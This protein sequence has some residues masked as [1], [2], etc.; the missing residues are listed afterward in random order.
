MT[1]NRLSR[2]S[3]LQLGI[4]LGAYAA[5]TRLSWAQSV[6]LRV[7]WFGTQTRANRTYPALDL[8]E[9]LHPGVTLNPETTA[10]ADYWPLLATQ[11]AG[12]NAPD[13][14]TM[15]PAYTGEYAR[16]DA[17]LPLDEF[18]G[19]GLDLSA[20]PEA[21]LDLGRID[22]KLYG[23]PAGQATQALFYSVTD[24]EAAGLPPPNETTTWEQ[25]AELG[26]E[27]HK[28]LPEVYG[29]AEACSEEQAFS[30]WLN[31]RGKSLY[32]ADGGLNYDGADAG[33]WFA[34]WEAMRQSGACVPADIAAM[35]KDNTETNALTTGYAAV[36][37]SQANLF[38]GYQAVNKDVLALTTYPKQSD[39]SGKTGQTAT[40]AN[41]WSVYSRTSKTE[42]AI[43]V[44]NFLL[45]NPEVA[46]LFGV[47]RGV[48]VPAAL[49]P[50]AAPT[51]DA[52]NSAIASYVGKVAATGLITPP[53]AP[54]GAGEVLVLLGRYN[55]EVSFGQ[56]DPETAGNA[57]VA[58]A[59]EILERA[60][61]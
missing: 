19:K 53:P 11:T 28:A 15:S 29:S 57:F 22:G 43:D 38:S 4:G 14:I 44:V 30:V 21:A 2:R 23:I 13:V 1:F 7:G 45:N 35:D 12:G 42:A 52:V 31:Q 33:Q 50:I 18:V 10:W 16:R 47:D 32:S 8:Y 3:A 54:L 48:P 58:E 36:S 9:Q 24:F 55:Q 46:K 37:F 25:F 41:L 34:M 39:G 5:S 49:Q 27:L 51:D 17:L 20:F 61:A 40:T 56:K 59:K 6:E 26:A 60:A